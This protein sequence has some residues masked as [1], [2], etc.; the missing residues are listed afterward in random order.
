MKILCDGCESFTY[1]SKFF[2]PSPKIFEK[3]E[4][5]QF[6]LKRFLRN[7]EQSFEKNQSF[8]R[9]FYD[10]RWTEHIRKL[11]LHFLFSITLRNVIN[12]KLENF[13]NLFI[14]KHKFGCTRY[15]TLS[16]LECLLEISR[17]RLLYRTYRFNI[18]SAETN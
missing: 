11:K 17:P 1:H 6:S 18:L 3:F 2:A 16:F 10:C 9:C 5:F 7:V 15:K 4:N 13:R 12:E 8:S 14:F